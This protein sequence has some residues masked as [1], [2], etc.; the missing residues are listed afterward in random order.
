MG[1]N[2]I[3]KPCGLGPKWTISYHLGRDVTIRFELY[4]ATSGL[5]FAGFCH[6]VRIFSCIKSN[7][8]ILVVG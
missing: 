2:T 5:V 1:V 6:P 8:K 3:L 7:I 4:N